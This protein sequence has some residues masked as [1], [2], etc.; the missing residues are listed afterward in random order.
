MVSEI[1][2][3][4]TL[5]Q[6]WCD[7]ATRQE[8]TASS[9]S[10]EQL[11]KRSEGI[12]PIPLTQKTVEL[13][14]ECKDRPEF[15]SEVA[16]LERTYLSYQK[17]LGKQTPAVYLAKENRDLVEVFVKIGVSR[18][19][20][21]C[22]PDFLSIAKEKFWHHYFPFVKL[23]V[24]MR[25]NELCLL[26]EASENTGIYQWL[27][28]SKI[29]EMNLDNFRVTYKGM[30]IGHPDRSAHFVPLK[31]VDAEGKYALQF[32]TTCPVGRGLPSTLDFA[33]S[34][35]SFTQLILP[36]KGTQDAEVYSVGFFPR[37][38]ADFGFQVFKTIPGIYRNHDSNV[39]RILAKRSFPLV[40]QYVFEEDTSIS[41]CL[42]S[43]VQNRD[44]VCAALKAKKMKFE[45]I[46]MEQIDKAI[47]E[48]NEPE[49]D[50]ILISLTEIRQMIRKGE[51]GV[52]MKRMDREEKAMT[53][54][55]RFE[56]AQ[57]KHPY[58]MLGSNCTAVSFQQEAFAVA[59]LDAQLD[60]DKAVKVYDSQVDMRDHK[61]GTLDRIREVF[62]RI[63]LHFFAA[64]PLTGPLLGTG[65]THPD[66][67]KFNSKWLIPSVLSETAFATH[68]F[69]VATFTPRPLFPAGEILAKDAPVIEPPGFF[70][71]FRY[72]WNRDSLLSGAK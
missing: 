27:P 21:S 12:A 29:K 40:K 61:F 32:V 35:H 66:A 4:G 34:G 67:A 72:L 63:L 52:Q 64:L 45:P 56:N 9:L 19:F 48:R 62:E 33:M 41:P 2:I 42:F 51:L 25:G 31:T 30:A 69:L 36:K 5:Y 1:P 6:W 71:R 39:S 50:R 3:I 18:E 54:L 7:R 58:H 65:S 17:K 28:W 43:L 10:F 16:K 11:I 46:T 59:F 15:K 60:S 53:M 22:H 49:L 24:E 55:R 8:L 70:A 23:P 47:L 26:M 38:L 44:A 14:E 13:L 20:L 57:G 68:Q 37:K